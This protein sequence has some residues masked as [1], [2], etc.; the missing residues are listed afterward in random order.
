MFTKF[1]DELQKPGPQELELGIEFNVSLLYH[2]ISGCFSCWQTSL[3]PKADKSFLDGRNT[4]IDSFA[5]LLGKKNMCFP[6]MKNQHNPREGLLLAPLEW[7]GHPCGQKGNWKVWCTDQINH[8]VHYKWKFV[9]LPPWWL[10]IT[11]NFRM[12]RTLCVSPHFPDNSP[13]FIQ[14]SPLPIQALQ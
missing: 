2:L 6:A 12:W 11:H 9:L 10:S 3:L 8:V 4:A 5:T 14:V 7:H 13:S 1:K